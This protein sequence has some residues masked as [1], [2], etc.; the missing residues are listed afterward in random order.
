MQFWSVR[1]AESWNTGL[2]E[3]WTSIVDRLLVNDIYRD[4]YQ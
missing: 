2:S 1:V 3:G 4:I